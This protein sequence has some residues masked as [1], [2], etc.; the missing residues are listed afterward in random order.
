M[1]L[2]K[3]QICLSRK[4]P[5]LDAHT[6]AD[7]HPNAPWGVT[8]V[9]KIFNDIWKGQTLPQRLLI[10][11]NLSFSSWSSF[12]QFRLVYN[13]S[14]GKKLF[15]IR[16]ILN[17]FTIWPPKF[18]DEVHHY[19]TSP[20]C[21]PHPHLNELITVQNLLWNLSVLKTPN[22]FQNPGCYF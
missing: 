6:L 20:T 5:P 15:N 17:D 1:S 4:T 3:N 21:V 7:K 16:L 11:S 14:G 8:M 12:F 19:N 10:V 2:Y 9:K 13:Q 22:F 18:C